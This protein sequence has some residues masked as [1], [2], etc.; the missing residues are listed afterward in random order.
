MTASYSASYSASLFE[1]WNP[2]LSAYSTSI[3]YKEVRIKPAQLLW[4]LATPSTDNLQMGRSDA[5]W[6]ISMGSSKLNSMMKS[7]KIFPLI[8]VLGLYQMSNSLSSMAHFTS[9]PK[10]SG[11]CNICFIGCSVGI[12]I[13]W[14][15]KYCRSLL[16]MDT[17]ART[18]FCIFG[19]L[20]SAPLR[21]SAVVIDQL[22]RSV[23]FSN[24]GGASRE[25]GKG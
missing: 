2:N 12:S 13:V 1:V 19:Y 17:N 10:V 24:Q 5:S 22:L 18:S 9:L 14:A 23:S 20:S 8:V 7:A 4:A 11:L 16:V 3:P 6:A 15:W 21:V 25:I